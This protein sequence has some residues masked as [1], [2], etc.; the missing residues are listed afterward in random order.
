MSA[1]LLHLTKKSERPP[2]RSVT[3]TSSPFPDHCQVVETGDGFEDL[4]DELSD[5]KILYCLWRAVEQPVK[6]VV[7]RSCSRCCTVFVGRS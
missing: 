7:S 2:D 4:T 5:G 6:L 3:D 1:T